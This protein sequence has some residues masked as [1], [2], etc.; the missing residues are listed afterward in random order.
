MESQ[1]NKIRVYGYHLTAYF[2]NIFTEEFPFSMTSFKFVSLETL[3]IYIE[4]VRVEKNSV[5]D[6]GMYP[7]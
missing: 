2:K 3:Y 7:Q 4:G 5:R 1:G 6:V